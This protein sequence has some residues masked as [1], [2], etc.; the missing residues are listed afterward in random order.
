MSTP[1]VRGTTLPSIPP[2]RG[3][4]VESVTLPVLVDVHVAE[5]RQRGRVLAV[6][7]GF[8]PGE[9]AVIAAAISEIA[10]NM[11]RYGRDGSMELRL[12]KTGTTGGIRIIARDSG[13]GIP[14]I[15]LAMRDGYSTSRSLGMGLSAARRVMDEFSIASEKGVGTLV[16]MAKWG[17]APASL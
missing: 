5:V 12:L 14:D 7:A 13:P 6:R 15:D 17:T 9:Q 8:S 1:H 16:V 2:D 10:R 3:R 4:L 11:V